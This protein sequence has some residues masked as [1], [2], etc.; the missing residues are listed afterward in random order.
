MKTL[1]LVT[2]L[3]T[4]CASTPSIV[5]DI[6]NSNIEARGGRDRI[7]SLN[8]IRATGTITGPGG[9]VAHVVREVKKP[10]L[11]RL[12]FDFQGTTSVFAHDGTSGW[13][14]APLQGQFAP[15]AMPAEA[16]AASGADQRDIEGTL[17]DWKKKGHVVSFVGHEVIDGK[18]TFKLKTDMRGGGTRYDY[19]DAASHQIVRSDVTRIVQGHATILETKFSDFRATDGLMFPRA[20]EMHVKDRPEV[21]RVAIDNIELNPPLDDA[22]F[23]MP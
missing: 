8:S 11:F 3:A 6:V 19:V 15:L 17:V 13:Q 21:L 5:D 23:R 4:S 2:L 20:I 1:I 14:V 7:T 16:D 18:D 10:G 22:R 9:R 12:E